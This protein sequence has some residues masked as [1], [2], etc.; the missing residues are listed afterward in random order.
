MKDIE[1][2]KYLTSF[3]VDK[4]DNFNYEYYRNKH[5]KDYDKVCY[6]HSQK[7]QKFMYIIRPIWIKS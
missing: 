3:F 1:K 5:S 4:I 6:H 7:I 2:L